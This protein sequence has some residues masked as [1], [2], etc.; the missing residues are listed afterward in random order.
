M[1]YFEAFFL[2]VSHVRYPRLFMRAGFIGVAHAYGNIHDISVQNPQ[3]AYTERE[4][5]VCA[6]GKTGLSVAMN[7]NAEPV[8]REGLQGTQ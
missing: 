2:N 1:N 5:A 6:A 8:L 7:G 3:T 4:A